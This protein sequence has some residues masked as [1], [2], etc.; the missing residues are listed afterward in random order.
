MA[1]KFTLTIG[2]DNELTVNGTDDEIKKALTVLV[3]E[4]L[5]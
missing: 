2:D 5:S 1:E 3:W 4:N